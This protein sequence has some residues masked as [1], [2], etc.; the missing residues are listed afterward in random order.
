MLIV[1]TWALAL[2]SPLEQRTRAAGTPAER[3]LPTVVIATR[4]R[5]ERLLATLAR[6]CSLP[7]RPPIIVVDNASRDGTAAAVG[8]DYPGVRLIGSTRE[9]GSAARTLGVTASDTPLIAFSDDDSWWAPGSLRRAAELFDV[10]PALGLIAARIIVEPHGALDPTCKTMRASPLTADRPLPG[11]P[12]LGFLACAAVVRRSAVLGCGGFHARYGFGG[13]EHLLAVD[14]ASAGWGL[15]YVDEIVAHHEP[16]AGPRDWQA[17][18]ELRNRLWSTWL[19]RPLPR[20]V[21]LTLEMTARRRGGVRALLAAMQGIGWVA[22]ERRV[23][24]ARVEGWLR[25]LEDDDVVTATCE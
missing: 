1:R 2:A 3:P 20:A 5:R 15:A 13:E 4:D 9:L 14:M 18:S 10:Y 11:P 19:R 12:I 6:L 22:S 24:P 8:R 25:S 21:R 16:A 7:D 23:V 17:M